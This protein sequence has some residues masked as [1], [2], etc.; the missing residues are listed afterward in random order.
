MELNPIKSHGFGPV[1]DSKQNHNPKSKKQIPSDV[2]SD[3]LQRKG[4]HH[5]SENN[6]NQLPG[7]SDAEYHSGVKRRTDEKGSKSARRISAKSIGGERSANRNE[8]SSLKCGK[9][10]RTIKSYREKFNERE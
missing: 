9:T 4:K 7:F 10:D 3:L 5:A 2:Y 6:F 1:L 8:F